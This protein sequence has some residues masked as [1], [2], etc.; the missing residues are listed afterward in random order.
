MGSFS[1]APGPKPTVAP[2]TRPHYH[3]HRERLRQRFATGGPDALA[4]YEILELLLFRSIPRRD[5]KQLAKD[6]IARFGSLADVLTAS[7]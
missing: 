2:E 3:G 1:E 6:L 7:R 4:D 5:T